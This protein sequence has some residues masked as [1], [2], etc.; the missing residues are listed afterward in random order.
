MSEE[1][2]TPEAAPETVS[3]SVQSERKES[4]DYASYRKLLGEKKKM[5]E[6]VSDYERRFEQMEIESLEREGDKDAMI[7]HLKSEVNKYKG[8]YENAQG[9]IKKQ[10][11]EFA[12]LLAKK[13]LKQA[14]TAAGC[15]RPDLVLKNYAED[16]ND[17]SVDLDQGYEL[18]PEQV[19]GF[20][21]RAQKDFSDL[22]LFKK[23]APVVE[24]AIPGEMPKTDFK[25]LSLEGQKNELIKEMFS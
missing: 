5:Q 21:A 19:S 10:T 25:E 15:K 13:E 1:N 18:D 14:L 12:M 23:S 22:D 8:D 7:N 3:D 9:S 16:L 6:K 20:V 11:G 4:V 2:Q 17:F 24:D